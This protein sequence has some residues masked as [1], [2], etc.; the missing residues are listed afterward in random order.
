MPVASH[1]A[2]AEMIDRAKS[3][4]FAYPAI[5]VMSSETLHAALRGF[6][7]AGSDGIIQITLN[8]AGFWSGDSIRDKVHGA[9]A[10]AEFAR[11]VAARYPT[12]V[13]LH[14][15]HCT[16][17]DYA[18]FLPPLI[19]ASRDR[20]RGTGEPLFQ[21]HM[22]DGSALPLERN[23]QI[24][25]ELLTTSAA[26]N[27]LLELEIGVVGEKADGLSGVADAKLYS[28]PQDALRTAEVLGLGER[29]RYLLA[30]AFGNV[31]G[32]YQPGNVKLRPG[33]LG[34]IQQTVGR[35]VD[36]ERPFDLVFHGGSGS[37][38]ADIHD[39]IGHGVVK[40]NID[41]D[42]M[43][44][45]T[46]PIAHHMLANYHRVLRI[47]GHTPEKETFHPRSYLQE[48]EKSMAERVA[49]ACQDLKSAGNA[50][51]AA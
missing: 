20:V 29:G 16:G 2:Y 28:T 10:F 11:A 30:A 3:G 5:N 49:Q 15:D 14:T 40:M 47:D 46:R 51:V 9:T 7:E 19:A 48:A 41:T 34:E 4:R 18:D 37:T 25:D 50:L 31:H 44:A 17:K 26:A 38:L 39:A 13:A 22:W 45:F 33:V 23:L 8:S 36:R 21:S 35:R 32:I 43:Y 24:A 1:A 27:V 42:T 12:T 6:A